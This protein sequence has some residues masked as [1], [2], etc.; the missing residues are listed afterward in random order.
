MRRS[1]QKVA[2][3]GIS[4]ALTAMVIHLLATS[5]TPRATAGSAG[6]G[7]QGRIDTSQVKEYTTLH[8][9]RQDA[10]SV[11]ILRPSSVTRIETIK[12]IPFTVTTASVVQTLSGPSLP[13]TIELRQTGDGSDPDYPIVSDTKSYLAY[14]QPFELQP[15]V[16]VGNEY[17]VIGSL[18]GL[19]VRAGTA[20][21]PQSPPAPSTTFDRV[22][23][24]ATA[25]PST[26]TFQQAQSS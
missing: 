6:R 24:S 21:A 11:A 8:D 25:L 10:T 18:Q 14:L 16:P 23:P 2:A 5:P 19:F 13:S 1:I 22:D 3:F 9:L 15:G 26:I 7:V 17:V 12:G 20:A 4:I